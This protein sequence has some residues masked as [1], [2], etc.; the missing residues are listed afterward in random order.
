MWGIIPAAGKGSRIQPLAFS[1]ELLP[2]GSRSDGINERPVAVSEYLIERM[3]TG[4]ADKICMVISP[5]KSDIIEY[6]G[7]RLNSTAFAYVVQSHPSGLCDAVFSALPVIPEQEDVLIGLPDTIWF[8]QN[9]YKYLPDG[10][11]SF[12]LFPVNN[13][14]LFDAVVTD[15]EGNIL[16]IEVK[17]PQPSSKW[18]WGAFKMPGAVLYKLFELWNKRNRADEYF[19]TLIN[20]FIAEG[21]KA[22]GIKSGDAYVD[23]GTIF[24]YREAIK[25]LYQD[26]EKYLGL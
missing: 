15:D 8:P 12:L 3:T 17:S 24:G 19:G 6:Y 26:K 21:G 25:L 23:V 7:E 10:I 1:K 13:P 4:G 22:L 11:L 20:A 9:G 5:G 2:V 18:I 14:E 16:R